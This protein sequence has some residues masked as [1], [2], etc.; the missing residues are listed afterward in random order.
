MKLWS[1]QTEGNRWTDS[2]TRP[3][4]THVMDEE[5]LYTLNHWL[6]TSQGYRSMPGPHPIPAHGPPGRAA[7]VS[8]L[9]NESCTDNIDRRQLTWQLLPSTLTLHGAVPLCISVETFEWWD[10]H[11]FNIWFN[12]WSFNKI[13]TMI[14]IQGRQ[15]AIQLLLYQYCH[16]IIP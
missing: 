7:S 6:R 2:Q 14:S 16:I 5:R 9:C 10:W 12:S 4:K 13:P 8:C 1:T 3:D 11:L 15:T